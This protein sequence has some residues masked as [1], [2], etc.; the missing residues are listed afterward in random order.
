VHSIHAQA[1]LLAE[2][3]GRAQEEQQDEGTN[4]QEL[5]PRIQRRDV[6]QRRWMPQTTEDQDEEAPHKAPRPE[7][8]HRQQPHERKCGNQPVRLPEKG[9]SHVASV[10]LAKGYEI[11]GR[12]EDAEPTGKGDRVKDYHQVIGQRSRLGEDIQH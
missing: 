2:G 7:Q 5:S 11:H 8:P 10:K 4:R 6:V 9:I 1:T 3:A 12:D